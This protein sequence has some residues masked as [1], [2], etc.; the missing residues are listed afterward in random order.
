M[1]VCERE[2]ESRRK[3]K[4]EKDITFKSQINKSLSIKIIHPKDTKIFP[5]LNEKRENIRI[6]CLK[7]K[8]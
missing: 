5:K 7:K 2:R 1:C 6:S 3:L 8:K 4:K